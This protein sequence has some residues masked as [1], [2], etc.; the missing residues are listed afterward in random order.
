MS[1][2][3]D[4]SD[5]LMTLACRA[6]GF[7]LTKKGSWFKSARRYQCEGC[8]TEA[9]ITYDDKIRLFTRASAGS[10]RGK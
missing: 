3:R 4:L 1:L 9:R 10:G 5:K 6:C 8:G 7:A 2:S